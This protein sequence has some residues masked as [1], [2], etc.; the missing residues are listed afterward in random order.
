MGFLNMDTLFIQFCSEFKSSRTGPCF[1]LCNGFSEIY[2]LCKN[3]GDFLWIND[4]DLQD[5]NPDLPINKGTIFI[6]ASY[7]SHLI[8]STKWAKKYPDIHF[9]VGGPAV[10]S[11]FDCKSISP[12]NI[13]YSTKSVEE[14]FNE[15]NFSRKWKLELSDIDDDLSKFDVLIFSYNLDTICYWG[16][17]IFCN[18]SFNSRI[19]D[20]VDMS[21]INSIEFDGIK[22]VKVGSPG[23]TSYFLEKVFKNISYREDIEYDF[24]MRCDQDVIKSLENNLTNFKGTIPNL[25]FRFGIEFPSDKMLKF[26]K[27]G[28]TVEGILKAL[29]ISSKFDNVNF[30]TLY[31]IGWP[32]L[33]RS[34]IDSLKYFIS[35]VSKVDAVIIFKT[36]FKINT[37]LYDLY[38]D[39]VR[40]HVYEE[41]FY[42]GYF[43][44]LTDDELKINI[45]ALELMKQ[46]PV[47]W[48]YM[49]PPTTRRKK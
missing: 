43:V 12:P 10:L 6:S 26:I 18:Y 35:K 23:I 21:Y 40:R 32:T 46:I 13:E 24:M 39:R 2:D 34:D 30:Y 36:F 28:T 14:Y 33:N 47:N 5:K 16:K 31:M 22:Q 44:E 37:P 8:Q 41:D 17:C 48:T 20:C 15:P 29:S 4:K 11:G 1:A 3:K 49:V 27:K 45:E 38:K 25:K 9:V 7:V 19:R 42:R